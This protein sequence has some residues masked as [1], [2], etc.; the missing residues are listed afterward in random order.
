[1][2]RHSQV[3][4]IGVLNKQGEDKRIDILTRVLQVLG[5]ASSEAKLIPKYGEEDAAVSHRDN[6][7]ERRVQYNV[8]FCQFCQQP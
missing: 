6:L 5:S 2:T 1:M 3:T 7:V 4:V 8:V